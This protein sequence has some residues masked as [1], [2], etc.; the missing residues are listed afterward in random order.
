MNANESA[1]Q[2]KQEREEVLELG[3]DL[4]KSGKGNI[5]TSSFQGDFLEKLLSNGIARVTGCQRILA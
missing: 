1:D 2:H 4:T 3:A 5:Y